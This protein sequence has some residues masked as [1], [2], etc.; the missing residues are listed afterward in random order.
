MEQPERQVTR[1]GRQIERV[2][3]VRQARARGA[4]RSRIAARVQAR[5]RAEAVR[6]SQID[7]MRAVARERVAGQELGRLA[8]PA[9]GH[10]SQGY[11]CRG[12]KR[13]AG[14]GRFHD[15]IDIAAPK[16]TAVRASASGVVTFAGWNPWDRGRR[17]YVVI[18][19]H[20][21]DTETVY[22]HL[23]PVR[24][25]RAG[26]RVHRGERIGYVGLTGHTTG[27][28]VHWEVKHGSQPVHPRRLRR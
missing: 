14:C 23:K 1:L 10:V 13:D 20:P 15:G 6:G 24:V 7:L 28:H 4:G 8:R 17:A 21:E 27:P 3:E 12:A 18:I 19:S 16:G 5:E 11:G 26:E 2:R 25:V 22:A 9:R